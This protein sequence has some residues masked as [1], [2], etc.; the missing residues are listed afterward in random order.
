MHAEHLSR[1]IIISPLFRQRAIDFP[2]SRNRNF[3]SAVSGDLPDARPRLCQCRIFPN[4][5]HRTGLTI[6]TS[7]QNCVFKNWKNYAR[8]KDTNVKD[9]LA[10]IF[11]PLPVFT[12]RVSIVLLLHGPRLILLFFFFFAEIRSNS[13]S[14]WGS[15]S[16]ST[17][18][19]RRPQPRERL[20]AGVGTIDGFGQG[21]AF[22]PRRADQGPIR[23]IPQ[24][25]LQVSIL[26]SKMCGR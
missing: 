3:S 25:G 4:V 9:K 12:R 19:S 20:A 7:I 5:P 14:P 1:V 2:Q 10:E 22:S 13:I 6:L 15:E 23:R 16:Q 8:A 17:L 11:S 21:S 18:G 24:P 26:R